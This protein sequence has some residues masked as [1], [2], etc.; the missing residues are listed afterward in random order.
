MYKQLIS[1][2]D[3]NYERYQRVMLKLV[4]RKGSRP[5]KARGAGKD[6]HVYKATDL[7]IAHLVLIKNGPFNDHMYRAGNYRL[8]EDQFDEDG[9]PHKY[10]CIENMQRNLLV[11]RD[12]KP[13]PEDD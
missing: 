1:R 8:V 7:R 4:S 6:Q 13:V 12:N 5:T 9:N 3:I 10:F 2:C 11:R